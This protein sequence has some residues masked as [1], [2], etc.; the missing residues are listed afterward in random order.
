MENL[1]EQEAKYFMSTGKRQPLTLVRGEG[2]KVW[3]DEGR[4]YLDF[5]A[6]IAVTGLGHCHPA[7]VKAIEEQSRILWHVSNL[8]Y[9]VPQVELAQLLVENSCMDEVYFQNSGTEANEAAIKLARKYGKVHL[10]GAYEV[11][12][13][14]DSFHGRTFAMVAATGQPAHQAIY[15]PLPQGFVNVPYNDIEALMSATSENTCAIMLEV[16]QGEGGVNVPSQDY[17]KQ[18]R[19]WCDERGMLLIFDEVQT[20]IGRTGT[21]F[22]YQHFGVEPDVM[23]LAKALGGGI[24]IG[25][26]MAKKAAS[27]FEPGDH[28]STFSG[29]PLA[30][31]V[32]LANMR[33]I[34]DNDV[35]GNAR[36][37][38]EHLKGKLEGLVAKYD[39]ATEVRGMG[40]LL[41]LGLSEDVAGKIVDECRGRGLLVNPVR[42]NAVRTMPALIVTKA[43]VDKAVGIL[44]SALEAVG[45]DSK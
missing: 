32:A 6:G 16:I 45:K 37:S 9:T 20:G 41:A 14:I 26:I 30:T 42:P 13:A 29:N 43:E 36:R 28:G 3:D 39:L 35:V 5:V 10:N 15:T 7:I 40:L 12:S 31:A 11:I 4:E 24:P 34:L 44:D 27:A 18:V 38:G 25:A 17:L 8:Y 1:K 19:D 33:Y 21:L 2:V 22:A 23:T